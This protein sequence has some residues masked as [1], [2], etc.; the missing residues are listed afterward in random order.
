MMITGCNGKDGSG[1]FTPGTTGSVVTIQSS[2]YT[3]DGSA[4][5]AFQSKIKFLKELIFEK[6]YAA[7]V[8]NFEF[9]ITQMKVVTEGD[10]TAGASQEAILGLVDVSNA[11]LSSDWG[12]IELNEG[13]TISEIHF[14]IHKDAENCGGADYSVSYNGQKLNK[15]LEFK[16]RFSP[17]LIVNN[18]DT[19][20]LQLGVIAKAMEDATA[21]GQFNDEQISNYL[22]VNTIGTAEEL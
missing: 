10:S 14:E 21:A 4:V 19:I 6:A 17:A 3:N 7:P 12:T 16:F 5:A 22:Q 13:D 15:D 8:T 20:N 18:G 9:C 2:A 11:N 1:A